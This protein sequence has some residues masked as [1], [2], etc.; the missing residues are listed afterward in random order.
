VLSVGAFGGR[1]R[2]RVAAVDAVGAVDVG[3]VDVGAVNVDA[4]DV[5]AV[6]VG[7]WWGCLTGR[8]FLDERRKIIRSQQQRSSNEKEIR[9]AARSGTNSHRFK[10]P[11]YSARALNKER[12]ANTT[13]DRKN[14]DGGTD[15]PQVFADHFGCRDRFCKQEVHSAQRLTAHSPQLT[16]HSPPSSQLTA[17]RPTHS[18]GAQS[19]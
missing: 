17:H 6:D 14:K 7:P 18:R 9:T 5:D 2:G 15:L 10:R 1:G 12:L 3:A 4:V 11:V 8:S 19:Q 16:A 13:A